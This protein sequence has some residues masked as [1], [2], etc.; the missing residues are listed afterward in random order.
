[1]VVL[2]DSETDGEVECELQARLERL[3]GEAT[4]SACRQARQ[5]LVRHFTGNVGQ[6]LTEFLTPSI[7]LLESIRQQVGR[8]SLCPLYCLIGMSLVSLSFVLSHRH[9]SRLCP[10]YCPIGMSLVSLSFALSYRHV[11]RLSVLCTVLSACRS[12][13]SVLCTVL[14]ACRSSLSVLFCCLIGILL[15]SVSFLLSYRHVARL[16]LSFVLS[17]RHWCHVLSCLFVP[18]FL[19]KL[20]VSDCHG[21]LCLSV[22][23]SLFACA[24]LLCSS[25]L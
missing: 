20:S 25:P 5:V 16:S 24:S 9:V 17:D 21:C 10:L 8:S 19:V 23:L 22:C 18:S 14:S 11:A 2:Q 4:G 13:L 3:Y 12:S 7:A 1:M 6:F 15:V